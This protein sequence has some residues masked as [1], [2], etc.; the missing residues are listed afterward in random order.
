MADYQDS[1]FRLAPDSD[2]VRIDPGA[3]V[4]IYE[5]GTD[6]LVTEVTA[7]NDG[8]WSV[9]TLATG[10]YDIRIAGKIV[11]TIQHVK[12]DHTHAVEPTW[13][14]SATGAITADL[15]ESDQHLIHVS[16]VSGTIVAIRV[17]AQHVTAAGDITVHLLK[18]ASGGASAL[19]LSST[20][21]NHRIN[22]GAEE[23][24]Y[25]HSDENPGITVAANDCIELGIDYHASGVSGV[26]VDVVFRPD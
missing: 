15:A 21:W 22:P 1:A 13:G 17:V 14:F 24:R 12:A 11:K 7:D 5:A 26:T 2:I 3:L 19:T 9:P 16:P 20:V 25:A 4:Q 23:Y 8:N 18:G 10:T 6:T